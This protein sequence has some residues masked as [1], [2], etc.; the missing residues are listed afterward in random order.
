M[1]KHGNFQ[2]FRA[3][4][5]GVIWKK[6]TIDDKTGENVFPFVFNLSFGVSVYLQCFSDVVRNQASY[7]TNIHSS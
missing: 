1:M 4:P 3:Y 5:D 6:L 7:E 2:L